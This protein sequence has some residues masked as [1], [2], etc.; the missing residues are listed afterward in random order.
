MAGIDHCEKDRD[1]RRGMYT[2]S[3]SGEYWTRRMDHYVTALG[4]VDYMESLA[5]TAVILM[6]GKLGLVSLTFKLTDYD[7]VL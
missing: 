5:W 3:E 6:T 2:N 4:S 1:F 7:A